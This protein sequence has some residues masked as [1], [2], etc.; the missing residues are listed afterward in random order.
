MRCL[1]VSVNGKPYCRAGVG[2]TGV[3]SA[4]VNWA[5]FLPIQEGE[6]SLP[7][8][9][10]STTLSVSGIVDEPRAYIHWREVAHCLQPG[11]TVT[12]R[13]VDSDEPDPYVVTPTL[14]EPEDL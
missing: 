2:E 1:E 7:V 14:P 12:I 5:K 3:V 13:V 9:P 10:D 8:P 4:F 11:D 6:E